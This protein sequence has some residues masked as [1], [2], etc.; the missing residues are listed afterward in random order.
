[1]PIGV[2]CPQCGTHYQVKD[3]TAGAKV[4]CR[5]C[6]CAMRIPAGGAPPTSPP[7]AGARAAPAHR[8]ARQFEGRR[9]IIGVFHIVVGAL[10]LCWAGLLILVIFSILAGNV[11]NNPGDPPPEMTATFT[12][13]LSLLSAG[14]GVLQLV[15]GVALL[16]RR[17]GCRTL[18]IIAAVAS[19]LSLWSGCLYPLC[20]GSGIASLIILLGRDAQRLLDR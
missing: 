12:F 14:L 7:G 5:V 20:L 10:N 17:R 6:N 1:M 9:K 8:A 2:Q 18:G 15:A 3:E 16:N 19:C 11:P 13:G 4:R